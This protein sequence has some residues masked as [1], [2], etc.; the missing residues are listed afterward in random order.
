MNNKYSITN[1]GLIIKSKETQNFAIIPNKLL[2]NENLSLKA[3]GL[4]CILLSLPND[5]AVYKSQLQQFSNDG[6]DAT[7]NAFNELIDKGYIHSIQRL[8]SKGQFDGWD[9]VIYSESTVPDTK[10]PIPENPES[11]NPVSVNPS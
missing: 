10:N 6:R 4:I 7:V 11:D 1:R 2:R 3:K 8:N 9:Y 5:W